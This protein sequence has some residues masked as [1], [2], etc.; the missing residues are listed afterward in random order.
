MDNAELKDQLYEAILEIN[1][2]MAVMTIESHEY[3]QLWR[4]Q[5]TLRQQYDAL[6]TASL[7]DTCQVADVMH[8]LTELRTQSQQAKDDLNNKLEQFESVAKVLNTVSK[9]SAVMADV[10]R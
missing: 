1:Q 8:L 3:D 10:I 4:Q 9:V 6:I 5:R 2:L 7:T